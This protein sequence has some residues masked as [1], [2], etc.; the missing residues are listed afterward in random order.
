MKHTV[1]RPHG[2][3]GAAGTK[4]AAFSGRDKK[5]GTYVNPTLWYP[6][7]IVSGGWWS[8]KDM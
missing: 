4:I 7:Q 6:N 2:N 1:V 3:F 5:H 8:I